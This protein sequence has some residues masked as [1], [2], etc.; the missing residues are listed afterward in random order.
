MNS[1]PNS[2]FQKPKKEK[3]KKWNENE[4]WNRDEECETINFFPSFIRS[5]A[6][7]FTRCPF[8][9]SMCRNERIKMKWK[10]CD[11]DRS[12]EDNAILWNLNNMNENESI[13][14]SFRIEIVNK[15][16]RNGLGGPRPQS[17]KKIRQT[18]RNE[19]MENKWF[20]FERCVYNVQ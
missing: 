17:V 16:I 13:F 18:K 10:W 9:H 12:V 1:N 2:K 14:S 4:K 15:Y 6:I 8:W 7:S 20:M 5:S 19:M 11:D 3:E